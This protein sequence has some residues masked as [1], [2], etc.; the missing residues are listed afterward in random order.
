ML[1]RLPVVRLHLTAAAATL[2]A[3]ACEKGGVVSAEELKA[4]QLVDEA[5]SVLR[6]PD[7]RA[8][9]PSDWAAS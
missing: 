8:P 9:Q 2:H 5:L 1:N 6:G 3:E 4:A 7:V